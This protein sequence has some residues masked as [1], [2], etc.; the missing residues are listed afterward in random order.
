MSSDINNSLNP[1]TDTAQTVAALVALAGQS[2][3]DAEGHAK[4]V[5]GY[6]KAIG[7]QMKLE[8][9]AIENLV[10]AA[11]LHDIG[12]VAI[13]KAILGKIGKL[14]HDEFEIMKLHAT[15]ALG[16]VAKVEALKPAIPFIKH[17]HERFDGTGYPD[18]LV[19][20]DIPLGARIIS[21][22]EAFDILTGG[23]P[24]KKAV[25]L[26]EAMDELSR[27]CGTQFDPT[28]VAAIGL[29]VNAGDI[30]LS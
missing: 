29:A 2:E 11:A 20:E 4:R 17:H 10:N 30:K 1:N 14:S 26:T 13:S 9:A 15:I 28:V 18:G 8:G 5:A 25:T 6:A 24:W 23:T 27:C 22:C 19:G 12:K 3:Y 16:A 7:R 21:V